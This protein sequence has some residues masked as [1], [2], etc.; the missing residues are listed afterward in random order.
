MIWTLA[1]LAYLW[2]AVATGWRFWRA[3]VWIMQQSWRHASMVSLFFMAV[4]L[5][6]MV[7]LH[8]TLVAPCRIMFTVAYLPI[9]LSRKGGFKEYYCNRPP[10]ESMLRRILEGGDPHE[11][12]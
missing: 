1:G 2:I 9:A 7:V 3:Q 10:G 5:V 6:V 4:G 12:D 8:F 11:P